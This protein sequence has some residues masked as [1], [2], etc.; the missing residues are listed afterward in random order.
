MVHDGETEQQGSWSEPRKK[1]F[2]ALPR[3][4]LDDWVVVWSCVRS[5]MRED[6]HFIVNRHGQVSSGDGGVVH[7][8]VGTSGEG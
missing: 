1:A 7:K 3:G 8:R 2:P 4:L 5:R 6:M